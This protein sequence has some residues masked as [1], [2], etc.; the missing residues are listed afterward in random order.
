MTSTPSKLVADDCS[1]LRQGDI[2]SVES[3]AIPNVEGG[4]DSLPTPA[5]VAVI[6]QTCDI[7]QSGKKRCL[8]APVL[9]SPDEDCLTDARKGRRPLHLLLRPDGDG[10]RPCVADIE[11]AVSI[12]KERLHGQLIL[13]RGV[14]EDSLD[15]TRAVAWRIGRAFSRFAFP[16]EVYPVFQRLRSNAQSKIGTPSP[17][18]QVLDAVLDLRVAADQWSYP[19]RALTLYVILPSQSLISPD[20]VDP[21]WKWG[22]GRVSGLK[23]KNEDPPANLNRTCELIQANEGGDPSTLE[24]LWRL[25]GRHLQEQLLTPALNEDVSEFEVIVLSDVDMTLRDYRGTESLD[26]EVLSDSRLFGNS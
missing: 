10:S 19:G 15:A 5:G 13:A 7:V 6:S 2:V 26:L 20:E 12:P 14:G 24:Y 3:L 11:M 4:S 23:N 21:N 25:F 9:S 1:N 8:V 22:D 16:D 18:G 17:L